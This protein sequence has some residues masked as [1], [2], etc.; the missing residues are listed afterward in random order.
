MLQVVFSNDSVSSLNSYGYSPHPL[1]TYLDWIYAIIQSD[2]DSSKPFIISITSSSPLALSCML[3]SIQNVRSRLGDA[4]GSVSRIAVELNTS[5]PN[6]RGAPPPAYDFP[7]LVPLLAVLAEHY[8][9]DPTLTIGLKL[10]PY[11]YSTQ[12]ED[13]IRCISGFSNLTQNPFAFFT[14]TNTVGS[15]LFFSDQVERKASTSAGDFALPTALGGLAGESI[16]ALSLGNV[17]AFAGLLASS[18]LG[19]LKNIKIIGVGGV[20]SP[21][22]VARMR[23]A[24]ANVVG[25]ATLLGRMGCKAFERLSDFQGHH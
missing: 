1:A 23:Q 19:A 17:Y 7:S 12:F 20:T 25:C 13:A 16:H 9:N 21:S 22:G 6:I 2:P 24:G 5:C 14:C 18:Q 10:P 8:W 4:E 15:C 11:F 3:D